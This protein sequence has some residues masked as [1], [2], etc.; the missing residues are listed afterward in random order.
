MAFKKQFGDLRLAERKDFPIIHE[1]ITRSFQADPHLNWLLEFSPRKDKLS[2]LV[3]YVIEEAFSHGYIYMTK[4]NLGVAI[5][6]TN[7][8]EKFSF[9]L[10]RRNL[11][12]LFKMGI[13]CVVRNLKSLEDTN[14]HFPKDSDF[15]YLCM[16]GVHP[17][18][19]GKG[20][21][22]KLMNPVIEMCNNL[23]I[24]I[25]LETGNEKNVEL[26]TKKGFR[27]TDTISRGS[28]NTYY[29]KN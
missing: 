10:V 2:V 6:K 5:W 8:K 17:Q 9:E 21:A 13:K 22:S 28:L 11:S 7:S 18:A 23:Q 3:R 14:R 27:L 16:I 1:I 12:F 24:P 15:Y 29:M 26:Y 20:L 25:F 4:D 19:Q